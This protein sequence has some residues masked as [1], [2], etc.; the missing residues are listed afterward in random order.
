M[1]KLIDR[2]P[3]GELDINKMHLQAQEAAEIAVF[4]AFFGYMEKRWE[5]F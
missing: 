1:M 5:H 3:Y 2:D 4:C